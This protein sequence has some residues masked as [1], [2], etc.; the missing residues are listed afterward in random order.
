MKTIFSLFLTA[1]L[2]LSSACAE[3]A[4]GALQEM[5]AQGELLMVQGDYAGAAAKFDA[6]GTYSDASQMAMY[7]KAIAAAETFGLYSMAVDAFIDL[8]DFKDS[9]QMA[10]YYEGRAHEAAGTIDVATASDSALAQALWQLEEAEKVYGG[11]AFFKDSL[12][13]YGA[14]GD[15]IKE[16]KGEQS[17]R[18]QIK[19]DQE[20]ARMEG[21]YQEALTLEQNGDYT[22]A[23]KLYRS[24]NGYKD[25][26]ERI[27]TCGTAILDGK[28][29]AAVALM[30][31]G[32]YSEAI[33]AFMEI[34]TH[35]DSTDMIM[36]CRYNAAVEL[37]NAGKYSEAIA[38]FEA[39]KDYKDSAE[40]IKEC[41]YADAV[42]LM[43]AGKYSEAIAVFE[44]IKNHKDSAEKIKE[45]KYA[46]AFVLMNVG[47]Y[48]EAYDAFV[49]LNGYKDSE[50]QAGEIWKQWKQMM[51]PICKELEMATVGSYITFGAYEQEHNSTNGKDSIE[52]LVL[53]KE[54][55]RLL[56]ISRYALDCKSYNTE[57]TDVTW[58]TCSLRTWLNK[59]FLNAA[60]SRVEQVIIPTVTVSADQNPSYSTDPG[61]ATQDKVFLLS[62]TEAKKYFKTDSERRSKENG[63]S[64]AQVVRDR[65]WLRSPGGRGNCAAYV[66]EYGIE[67]YGDLVFVHY[68]VYP[69][70][71]INLAP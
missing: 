10:K 39:I 32:K 37:M 29:D 23:I 49:A 12:T 38:A 19:R 4:T 26:A 50:M 52:W 68:D 8:G 17:R 60:F 46:D 2:L 22:E 44:E 56:V 6:L 35:R 3:S 65:L 34:A 61:K 70:M 31:A 40:K 71:W 54:D 51:L 64:R 15:K 13:R 59:D 16:I 69:A 42:V 41:K 18:A 62:I 67:D 9:K 45:C 14:C 5:Y 21:V 24:L 36:L 57:F 30:E 43:D 55:N 7:C 11:L 58:E 66:S 25:S 20:L 27:A 47:K 33:A 53:A 1:I 28:Y 63:N 48:S